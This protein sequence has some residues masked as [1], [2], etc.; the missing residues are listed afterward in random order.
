MIFPRPVHE[1]YI[2]YSA[3]INFDKALTIKVLKET[4]PNVSI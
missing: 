2:A 1:Q 3:L 4:P